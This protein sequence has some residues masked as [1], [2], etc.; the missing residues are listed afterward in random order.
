[1]TNALLISL[2]SR[3][4]ALAYTH[5]YIFGFAYKGNIYSY[6]TCNLGAGM[7][8]DTASRGAGKSLRYKPTASEKKAIVESGTAKLICSVEYFENE[9]KSSRYNKGEIFEKLVTEGFGQE[10]VKDNVKFTQGGDVDHNGKSYQVKFEK[11]TFT[12]EQ[13]LLNLEKAVR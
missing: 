11:A 9:V 3:Y 2:I 13:T 6:E 7:V 8:L 12:N 5:D 4:S 10:W 1:M